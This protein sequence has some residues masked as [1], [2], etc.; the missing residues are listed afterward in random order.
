MFTSDILMTRIIVFAK[1]PVA[2]FAKTRLIPALGAEG[3]AALAGRMLAHALTH[4]LAANVGTVELCMSPAPDDAAWQGVTLQQTVQCSSQGEGNLGA[5][6]SR[7]IDRNLALQ[8]GPVLVTGTDCPSLTAERMAEASRQLAHHDA[9]LIPAADGGYVL[10]GLQA[11]CPSLFTDM[12][13]STPLV[14][15][16]TLRRMA[17]LS[18]RVWQGPVLHDID[19]PADLVHLPSSLNTSKTAHLSIK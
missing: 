15:A 18:L 3:A 10:I 13:W 16:E 7:A 11:P 4:A 17:D 14:A 9:V 2:G 5:R 12:A 8:Q 1:A 6:M 19:E